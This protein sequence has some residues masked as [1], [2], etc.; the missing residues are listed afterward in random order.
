MGWAFVVKNAYYTTYG[1]RNGTSPW[2]CKYS[3]IRIGL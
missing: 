1:P 3:F 2:S